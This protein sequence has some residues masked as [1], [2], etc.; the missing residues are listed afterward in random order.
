M[1]GPEVSVVVASRDRADRL[2]QLLRSL[3]RQTMPRERFEV[4]IVDDAS[5]DW[6]PALLERAVALGNLDL[7]FIR[8][9]APLGPG[10]A[11]DRGWRAARAPLIA[12]IDDDCEAEPGWLEALAAIGGPPHLI[13]QGRT[14]PN[15][16]EVDGFGP[17]SRTIEVTTLGP[18]YETC[19]IAYPRALL[20]LVGG[21]D[22]GFRTACED[23]DLAWRAIEA[24]AETRFAERALAFHA[25]NQLGFHG[26]LAVTAKWAD[27]PRLFRR[28]PVLREL[29]TWRVFW[30]RSHALLT[31]AVVGAL[32]ARRFPPALI[33]AIPYG[34]LLAG[35]RHVAG[36]SPAWAAWFALH[37]A[38]EMANTARGAVRHRSLVL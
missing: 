15:P 36:V 23:T 38:L 4:V 13:V 34:Q 12:F 25:V 26:A 19:N 10:G 17:L 33:L 18:Y 27:V 21:F 3:R 7:R 20:E 5:A 16:A 29:L 9:P 2:D 37:D 6:T 1:S 22:P 30:R 32:M 11:R 28:H 14:E 31:L 8:H 24:G 35:R